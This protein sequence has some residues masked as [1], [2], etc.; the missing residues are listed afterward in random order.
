MKTL[1]I[2]T[3]MVFALS[4]GTA[5]AAD[6]SGYDS[7]FGARQDVAFDSIIVQPAAVGS[8][9][10]KAAGGYR[11]DTDKG[12]SHIFDSMLG[13]RQDVAFDSIIVQPAA[14]EGTLGK[15]A[16]GYRGDAD[17]GSQLYDSMFGARQDVLFDR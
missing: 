4:L 16:G 12:S 11:G 17:K 2:I 5:F 6:N 13:A 8:I 15:A 3:A 9:L 1:S 14:G 10:G 7:M